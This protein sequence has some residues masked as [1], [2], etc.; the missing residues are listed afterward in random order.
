M[1][2]LENR[3]SRHVIAAWCLAAIILGLSLIGAGL[4]N[5]NFQNRLNTATRDANAKEAKYDTLLANLDER[6]QALST[7]ETELNK[8]EHDLETRE[9]VLEVEQEELTAAQADFKTSKARI[10][11]L[12]QA[13]LLELSPKEE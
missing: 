11:E 13:L 12:C 8:R 4:L 1:S 9:A 10:E 5:T 3:D 2:N 6:E 7:R